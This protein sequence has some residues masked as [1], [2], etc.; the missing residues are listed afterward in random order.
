MG[1][2]WL[3]SYFELKGFKSKD[4]NSVFTVLDQLQSVIK[5]K[6]YGNKLQEVGVEISPDTN[7]LTTSKSEL[8]IPRNITHS[9]NYRDIYQLCRLIFTE[10]SHDKLTSYL[11]IISFSIKIGSLFFILLFLLNLFI[12]F[13]E[14]TLNEIII[15]EINFIVQLFS[16]VFLF[17]HFIYLFFIFKIRN[18]VLDMIAI[19]DYYESD[20]KELKKISIYEELIFFATTPFTPI[21]NSITF[22]DPR[23]T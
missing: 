14:S 23:P 6:K 22:L 19:K 10:F 2:I 17:I 5:S 15:I 20:I 18:S 9:L 12:T 13:T 7:R 3:V 8:I 1:L 21:I 11:R 16:I 4:N